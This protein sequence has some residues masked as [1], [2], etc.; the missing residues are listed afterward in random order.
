MNRGVLR[1]PSHL[2]V[3]YQFP[4]MAFSCS[5]PDLS[6]NVNRPVPGWPQLATIIAAKSDLESFPTFTDLSIKSL[7]Y[8][9]AELI[10]LRKKL[11]EAEW[12][13]FRQKEDDDNFFPEFCENL[14]LF[15][16]AREQANNHHGKLPEQWVIIEKIRKTLKKYR[17]LI[18]NIL[19]ET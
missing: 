14:E 6:D 10:Y 12:K 18:V 8:Y 17:K 2:D 13:D 5:G 19:E 4:A 16:L 15:I 11:H 7:L 3:Q 9:Q 1:T